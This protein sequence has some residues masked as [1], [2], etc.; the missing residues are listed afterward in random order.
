MIRDKLKG[1][2]YFTKKYKKDIQR[3]Q[4]AITECHEILEMQGV[5][6]PGKKMCYYD[7]YLKGL[8]AF[9]SGYSLGV[10]INELRK[11]MNLILESIY[12]TWDGTVYEDIKIAFELAI[13]FNMR[14]EKNIELMDLMIKYKYEDKYLYMLAK[15]LN[16][17]WEND[18]DKFKFKK[19]TEP[20]VEVIS[21][22]NINKEKAEERLKIYLDKQWFNMQ[23]EGVI[24]NKDHLKESK[25]RGYWCIEA[26][27]LVKML[28]LDDKVLK[29]SKYYPYDLA[30]YNQ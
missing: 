10:P 14:S 28:K 18:T 13:I 9:Y 6:A 19:A 16:A 23:K 27:G 11:N 24:T 21:L 8:Q 30:H 26:A 2:E 17:E 5:N 22:A 29:E 12:L 7:I 4:N 20:L 3:F 25:Y 1:E 15:Y